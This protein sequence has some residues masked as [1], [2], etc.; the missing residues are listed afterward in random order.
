MALASLSVFAALLI[1]P[2][3][4]QD[5]PVIMRITGGSTGRFLDTP[6][7]FT[8]SGFTDFAVNIKVKLDGT[9][10][11]EFL[12]AI[13]G[14][15]VLAVQATNATI[16]SDGSVRITGN[17]YGYDAIAGVG[18]TDCPATIVFR[19]GGV[20]IGGFDF[21]DCVIPEGL[22]DT[23]RVQVGSINITQY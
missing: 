21:D 4:A 17:E 3:N 14:V 6:H 9:A 18:Y 1:A 19:G 7:S 8:H 5:S 22:F 10:S 2:A 20:G 15:V 23:E 13:P 16:N 12:C 11:G